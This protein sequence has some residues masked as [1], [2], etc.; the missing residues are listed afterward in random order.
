MK[1]ISDIPEVQFGQVTFFHARSVSLVMIIWRGGKLKKT[2]LGGTKHVGLE[3][4]K[5]VGLGEP[6][7]DL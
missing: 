4:G 3:W 7:T 5:A 6:E 2:A 1:I